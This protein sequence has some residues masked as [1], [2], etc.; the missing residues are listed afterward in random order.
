MPI[1]RKDTPSR[2]QDRNECKHYTS[3]KKT[4]KEDFNHRCG[5]CDDTDFQKVRNFTIDH[6]VPQ[7]PTG[8]SHTI[9]PN[10][11][12]NLVYSCGYCNTSKTNKWPTNDS[13]KSN[14]GIVGFI[15]PIEQKYTNL[16]SRDING[17]IQPVSSTNN[18]AKYIIKELKLWLPIHEKMWKLEKVRKLNKDIEKRL[19]GMLEGELKVKLERE[20]YEILKIWVSIQ[21]NIFTENV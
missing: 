13:K 6:F 8:F 16:Y 2:R 9:A 11:Y 12:Y 20:H 4:L 15:D 3:Y 7:N 5:Y 10:Y 17:R 14:D 18:L 19:N 1:F 21:E